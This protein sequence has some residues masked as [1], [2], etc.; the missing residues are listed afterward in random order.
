MGIA[1]GCRNSQVAA[2][3]EVFEY[4]ALLILNKNSARFYRF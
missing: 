3:S 1:L 4:F 2:F